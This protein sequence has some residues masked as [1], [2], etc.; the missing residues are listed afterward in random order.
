MLLRIARAALPLAAIVAW[1]GGAYQPEPAAAQSQ[2]TGEQAVVVELFTSQGCS[3]CPPADRLLSRIGS[4]TGNG[5]PV[6]PLAFHVDYWNYI[7]WTDPF[8]SPAWSERQRR[9]AR[10]LAP[11]RVYTPQAVVNGQVEF[12][13]SN[14]KLLQQHLAQARNRQPPAQVNLT[15]SAASRGGLQLRVGAEWTTATPRVAELWV[16]L[17]ENGLETPVLRGENAQKTLRNDSVVR[18]LQPVATLSAQQAGLAERPIIIPLDS[19]WNER[20]LGVAAVLQDRDSLAIYGA[21]VLYLRDF[22][23]Q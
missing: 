17:F 23:R 15:G 22:R 19:A 11:G 20:N 9:Y 14:T 3:S 1:L 18:L 12:V 5:R 6:V 10:A 8:S 4:A 7:G 21:A 2:L 13:G 16:A